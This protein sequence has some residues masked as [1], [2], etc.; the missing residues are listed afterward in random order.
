MRSGRLLFLAGLAAILPCVAAAQKGSPSPMV[1]GKVASP[2]E[3]CSLLKMCGLPV[4]ATC[5]A[6]VSGGVAEVVYDEPRCRDPRELHASGVRAETDVGFR[7]YR[8]LGRRYRVVYEAD[9]RVPISAGRV[10]WLLEELPFAAR[11][12]SRYQDTQYEAEWIDAAQRRFRASKG[13]TLTG[14]AQVVAG[15]PRER[16]LYFFGRGQSKLGPW[17]LSG[18]S[19]VRFDFTPVP[20]RPREIAWRVRVLAAPDNAFVNMIMNLGLFKGQVL[21]H[22]RDVVDDMTTAA[23]AFDASGGVPPGPWSAD[24]Q[25]K[26][27]ELR[28][29]P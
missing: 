9:G 6:D 19:L 7:V 18:L 5:T 29:I 28:A 2:L 20:E 21:K 27:A 24:D 14:D 16:T 8:F 11:L 3:T 26:I 13:D 17:K 25:K 4:P 22:V 1:K 10:S 12:L 23:R 15:S